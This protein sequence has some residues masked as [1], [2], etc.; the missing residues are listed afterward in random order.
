MKFYTLILSFFI[1][2]QFA[3]AQ[4]DGTIK[5]TKRKNVYGL[6]CLEEPGYYKQK[7]YLRLF[8][9]SAAVFLKTSKNAKAANDSSARLL[10]TYR[11]ISASYY[12]I[13]DS[14]YITGYENLRPVVYRGIVVAGRLKLVKQTQF[15][16][17][18]VIF[19]REEI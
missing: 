18:P 17:K 16:S 9:D 14:V 6:Y 3:L 7:T 15:G 4:P 5:L 1:G 13:N 12:T 8:E 11:K 19:R 2:S 10:Y